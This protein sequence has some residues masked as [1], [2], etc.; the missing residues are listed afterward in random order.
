[1]AEAMG[2]YLVKIESDEEKSALMTFFKGQKITH[3]DK[4]MNYDSPTADEV[5]N[6]YKYVIKNKPGT[7]SISGIVSD[8]KGK[9]LPG[10]MVETGFQNVD[11]K[12]VYIH[13]SITDNK[14]FY[15]IEG[16]CKGKR[17]VMVKDKSGVKMSSSK[18]MNLH[19]DV[20]RNF[21]LK[22]NKE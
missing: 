13:Y 20:V 16:L 18:K 2:G 10:R 21:I 9:P 7:F 4:W 11:Y 19:D 5:V 15:R 8:K 1:M 3:T 12:G 22:E 14:G 17:I 6:W